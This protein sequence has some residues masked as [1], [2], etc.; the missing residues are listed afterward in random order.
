MGILQRL[1][2]ALGDGDDHEFAALAEIEQR[3][4]HQIPDIFDEQQ[5][6]RLRIK[7]LE[8]TPDHLGVEVA[9][10]ACVHLYRAG[11]GGLD[12][13]GVEQGFLI[14]F[15]HADGPVA[16]QLSDRSL[17]QGRLAR[18]GRAGDVQRKD[19]ALRQPCAILLGDEVVLR[20]NLLLQGDRFGMDM[21]VLVRVIVRM[22]VVNKIDLMPYVDFDLETFDK[23]VH[24][25]NPV[26]EILPMSATT[27]EGTAAWRDWIELQAN[28]LM[29]Q[30]SV[31]KT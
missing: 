19:V 18:A 11:A 29:S 13:F 8:R 22:V 4:A 2:G 21:G 6:L 28:S 27:G 23:F 16:C 9:A 10:R 31:D 24:A 7:G 30:R 25:I 12:A 17:E 1:V 5:R 3:R 26:A 20:Q 14:A 15:D